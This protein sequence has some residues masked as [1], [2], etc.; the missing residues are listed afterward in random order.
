MRTIKICKGLNIRLKGSPEKI[1]TGGETTTRY[2]IRPTDFNGITPKLDC[3]EGDSVLRGSKL[4]HDKNIPQIVFTSPCSGVVKSVVRGEKRKLLRIEIEADGRDEAVKF[5]SNSDLRTLLSEA[6]VMPYIVQ[7]PYGVVANPNL[8]PRDIFISFIDS[9]PLAS[10]LDFALASEMEYVNIAL[11]HLCTLTDGKIYLGFSKD[12]ALL[13][14]VI[15]NVKI[16]K[17]IFVG[18]HPVGLVGTQINKIKPINKGD[19]VWTINATNL[20]IIGRLLKDGQYCPDKIISVA[21]FSVKNPRYFRLRV[22]ADLQF[23]NEMLNEDNVRIISGNV[24][25]GTNVTDAPFLGYSDMQVSVIPE[26]NKY[27]MFGWVMPGA[28][29]FSNSRTF[30]SLLT[31]FK[32]FNID[33]NTHGDQR[34][35]VVTG[36]YEKVCPLDIY[37][38]LLVKAAITEDIDRMEELGIYEVI[39]EDL[40]LCEFVCTSKINVQQI[41]R[42]GLDIVRKEME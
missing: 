42:K 40:A 35:Y 39:E 23:V 12:S 18:K 41:L 24:L 36:Q 13:D 34:A 2:A 21:G 28:E 29:K 37:P 27:E 31:P 1:L 6:G 38:Q 9:A 14:K 10:D 7:R 33:T 26:G 4:F 11:G 22:G 16:E 30:L 3:Q 8:K 17:N 25:S 32:Y 19:V 5:D 15:D 20:P